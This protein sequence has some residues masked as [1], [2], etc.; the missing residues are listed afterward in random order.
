MRPLE[1]SVCYTTIWRITYTYGFRLLP[2][3]APRD[4]NYAPK[5]INYAPIVINYAPIVNNYAP[6]EHFSTGVTH[7]DG[8]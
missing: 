2:S 7:D 4:V 8:L 1:S 5:V 6:R 3:L